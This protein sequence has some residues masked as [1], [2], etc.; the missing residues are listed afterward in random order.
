MNRP[1]A[2]KLQQSTGTSMINGLGD[3]VS[4]YTWLYIAAPTA[5]CTDHPVKGSALKYSI[6]PMYAAAT[7]T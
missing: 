5:L 1:R 3:P 4:F 2:L 6:S 7:I